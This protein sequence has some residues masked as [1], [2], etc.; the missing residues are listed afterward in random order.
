LRFKTTVT[1]FARNRTEAEKVLAERLGHEE[2]YGFDYT[3]DWV[4]PVN[5]DR[6]KVPGCTCPVGT[7]DYPNSVHASYCDLAEGGWPEAD[8]LD[9]RLDAPADVKW[10]KVVRPEDV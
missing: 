1:I 10:E 2:D 7:Y 4:P 6:S 5:D 8:P 3:I 9:V